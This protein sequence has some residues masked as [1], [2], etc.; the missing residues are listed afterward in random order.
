MRLG[1]GSRFSSAALTQRERGECCRGDPG[2]WGEAR[3]N[4]AGLMP[5]VV[6][7]QP[8]RCTLPANTCTSGGRCHA[9][10]QEPVEFGGEVARSR[11]S[12]ERSLV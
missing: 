12:Q 9:C 5:L 1:P 11:N 6:Q 4:W 10:G 2:Q 7:G 3:V 8:G